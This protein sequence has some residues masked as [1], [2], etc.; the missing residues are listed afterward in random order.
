ML[1]WDNCFSDIRVRCV[2]ICSSLTNETYANSSPAARSGR[3]C[4][5]VQH[6]LGSS[7]EPARYG[8]RRAGFPAGGDQ[9]R[10]ARHRGRAAVRSAI[11]GTRTGTGGSLPGELSRSV[12][13]ARRVT[14]THRQRGCC[15]K[16]T[17]TRARAISLRA[18][19][20]C[21]RTNHSRHR[22]AG[23]TSGRS[24]PGSG[25][26]GIRRHIMILRSPVNRLRDVRRGT[27]SYG[28]LTRS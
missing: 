24:L 25:S 28:G 23:W 7:R 4:L 18:I 14:G 8:C 10:S 12:G 21:R 13:C 1:R 9:R 19:A 17:S 2:G 22:A 26:T 5:P 6:G 27:A 15:G 16:S 11:R 20:P 3:V